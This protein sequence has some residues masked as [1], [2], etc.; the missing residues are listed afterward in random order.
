MLTFLWE[1]FFTLTEF[2][3]W[4][5]L[6]RIIWFYSSAISSAAFF[7]DLFLLG[8]FFPTFFCSAIFSIGHFF[9]PAIFSWYCKC[10]FL[11]NNNQRNFRM[12]PGTKVPEKRFSLKDTEKWSLEKWSPV[13]KFPKKHGKEAPLNAFLIVRESNS[14]QASKLERDSKRKSFIYSSNLKK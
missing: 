11:L 10:I 4:T 13:R 6:I 9:T 7:P 3:L 14:S 1:I 5:T 12:V 8:H 2:N